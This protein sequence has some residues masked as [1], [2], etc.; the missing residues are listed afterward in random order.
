MNESRMNKKDIIIWHNDI[1]KRFGFPSYRLNF[2]NIL[3]FKTKKEAEALKK[4]ILSN[5]TL[6][7]EIMKLKGCEIFDDLMMCANIRSILITRKEHK[8][9]KNKSLKYE[10][11]ICGKQKTEVSMHILDNQWVCKNRCKQ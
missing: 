7:E 10:C 2:S 9:I 4:Q 11:A 6:V 8:P 5:Q 1:R 3:W